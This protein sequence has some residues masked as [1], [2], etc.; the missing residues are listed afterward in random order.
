MDGTVLGVDVGGTDIK[1]VRMLPDGTVERLTGVPTPRGDATGF[2]TADAVADLVRRAGPVDAVGVAVPGIVDEDAGVCAISVNLGWRDLDVRALVS[3]RVGAPVALAQDVRAGAR[4]EWRSGAGAGRDG[5]LLFAPLGTGLAVACLEADGRPIGTRWAGEV[6][7]LRWTSGP[8][9][10]LRVEE[11]VSAGG[12]AVRSGAP[13]ALAV[14]D[15]VRAGDPG[16]LAM[17]RET[18]DALAEVLAWGVAFASPGTI[19]VGGGLA[20]A[21]DLLLDPVRAA[22]AA[23]LPW[24]PPVPVLP[25]V[26]GTAAAAIG[27]ADLAGALLRS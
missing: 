17:W 9:A 19:V 15:A 11:V 10:G 21:G 18:V 20:Q 26:H 24:F 13:N 6:G 12:L 25:A 7:Q 3:D 8:H 1:A 16:A 14:A 23:R 4:A 27:A 2:A 5:G 22:L